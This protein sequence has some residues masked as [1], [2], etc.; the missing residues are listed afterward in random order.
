MNTH[1]H[2]YVTDRTWVP[3]SVHAEANLWEQ[4]PALFALPSPAHVRLAILPPVTHTNTH[5]IRLDWNTDH[6]QLSCTTL[7]SE[8]TVNF[9]SIITG[10]Y[11]PI[12]Q[13][14]SFASPSSHVLPPPFPGQLSLHPIWV[15]KWVAI[16]VITWISRL[17][18]IKRQTWAACGCSAARSNSHVSGDSP[19][20]RFVCDVK[21]CC[22]CSAM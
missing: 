2:R 16:H 8:Q 11:K 21:C 15:G 7:Q 22:S 12:R 13:I 17:K 10:A 20:A 14:S 6:V 4:W 5:N 18:T 19:T 1:L 3:P 9:C